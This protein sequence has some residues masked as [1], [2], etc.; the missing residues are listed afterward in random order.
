MPKGA[1]VLTIKWMYVRKHNAHGDVVRHRAR[2]KIKGCQREFGLSYWDTYAPVVSA[3]EVKLVLLLALH[4][5]LLCR[6]VDFVTAFL[7]GPIDCDV[8][9][10][11][12][13]VFNDGSG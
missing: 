12:P 4:F 6:H 7:N 2:I 11:K 10:E 9:M 5:G 1:K 3:E 13:E 8:Y